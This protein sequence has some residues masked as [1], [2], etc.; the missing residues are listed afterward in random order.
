MRLPISFLIVSLLPLSLL[1]QREVDQP[2]IAGLWTGTLYNDSTHQFH[3]YE[4]GITSEK[5]KF[6][7]FSHTTFVIGDKE[8]FGLKKLKIR[9]TADDKIIITDETLVAGNYPELPAKYMRQLN[10]LTLNT[11]DPMPSLNG[12]FA[13]QRTKQH[14]A[15]TG[16]VR[17]Q[18]KN[19]FW[20]AAI[21]PHLLS[22]DKDK[23]F[24]FI[25]E[26]SPPR[27][28]SERGKGV[29]QLDKEP[30]AEK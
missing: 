27:V 21:W 24:A 5:G 16:T 17:L 13:T 25:K 20:L 28:S 7:G 2:D 6:I 9:K 8:Y 3:K 26:Y 10:V 18:R 19:E 30:A 29:A 15:L 4:I 23:N 14:R 11:Q 22:L 12:L 1:A